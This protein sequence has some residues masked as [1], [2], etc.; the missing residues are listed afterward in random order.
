MKEEK[1]NK[2]EK[3][4][5]LIYI[6]I[7]LL[8]LFII[9]PPLFRTMFKVDKEPKTEQ[10]KSKSNTPELVCKY[11][12]YNY[13]IKATTTYEKGEATKVELIYTNNAYEGNDNVDDKVLAKQKAI[14]AEIEKFKGLIGAEYSSEGFT[15]KITI[16]REALD[17][18]EDKDLPSRFADVDSVKKYYEDLEYNCKEKN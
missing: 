2:K 9:L 1:G 10:K 6:A 8:S 14:D 16:P 18:N 11:N 12:K 7:F 15:T 13:S 17:S 5:A 3:G 4:N